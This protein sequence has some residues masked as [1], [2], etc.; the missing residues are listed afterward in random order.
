MSILIDIQELEKVM[1]IM[2]NNTMM[3]TKKK[4]II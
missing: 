2:K 4:K 1:M 3:A